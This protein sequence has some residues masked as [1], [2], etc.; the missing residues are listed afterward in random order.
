M[1][2]RQNLLIKTVISKTEKRSEFFL[3]SCKEKETIKIYKIPMR[4]FSEKV[5]KIKAK[6]YL[7]KNELTI[8]KNGK[9]MV[10]QE[11]KIIKT[12]KIK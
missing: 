2:F 12:R 8:K 9:I 6:N 7:S 5:R 10:D 1:M 3:Q 4:F 11:K